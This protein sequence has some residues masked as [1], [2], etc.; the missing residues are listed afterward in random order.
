[1]LLYKWAHPYCRATC[2]G[3]QKKRRGGG[4]HPM[5]VTSPSFDFSPQSTCFV[6]FS[7]SRIFSCNK[8][9]GWAVEGLCTMAESRLRCIKFVILDLMCREVKIILPCLEYT[10]IISPYYFLFYLFPFPSPSRD[11]HVSKCD[12]CL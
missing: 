7:E 4:T 10:D 11:N 6:F 12:I 1:M 8:Q 2:E 9:E 5:G 3:K